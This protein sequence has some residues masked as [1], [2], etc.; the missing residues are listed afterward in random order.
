MS[1]IT[2]LRTSNR[3][4]EQG[5]N[6]A[7][8]GFLVGCVMIHTSDQTEQLTGVRIDQ[9]I[10]WPVNQL[11]SESTDHHSPSITGMVIT[12]RKAPPPCEVSQISADWNSSSLTTVISKSHYS[13]TNNYFTYY[14]GQQARL[15]RGQLLNGAIKWSSDNWLPAGREKSNVQALR[16]ETDSSRYIVVCHSDSPISFLGCLY[17]FC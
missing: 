11:T 9:W 12:S 4:L 5:V 1:V 16:T 10:N 15:T 14:G 6:L 7:V 3:P 8:S 2:E 17:S 13:E